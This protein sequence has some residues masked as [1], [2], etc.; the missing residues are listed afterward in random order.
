MQTQG[1]KLL[2]D[3]NHQ[4]AKDLMEKAIKYHGTEVNPS[5]LFICGEANLN[6]GYLIIAQT[7]FE[8]CALFPEYE[9]MAKRQLGYTYSRQDE[10]EKAIQ[11]FRRSLELDTLPL[12][13]SEVGKLYSKKGE[14]TQALDFFTYALDMATAD[15][16]NVTPAELSDIYLHRVKVYE[17]MNLLEH[18]K[19]DY[20]KILEADPSFIQRQIL[21]QSRA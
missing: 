5:L 9:P 18:A 7:M 11:A 2:R 13:A 21:E 15:P 14:L 16:L 12:V 4:L 17:Q 6:L 3:G 19:A 20:K 1:T 8:K 10:P